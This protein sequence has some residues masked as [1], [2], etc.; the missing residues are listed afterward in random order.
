[1]DV[2]QLYNTIIANPYLKSLS[3]LVIFFILAKI[4]YIIFEKVF[5][6]AGES[7]QVD[8]TIKAED[9]AFFD[10]GKHDWHLEPGDFKL[11]IGRS[12]R[13]IISEKRF[14]VG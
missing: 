11:L 13:E 2:V 8:L 10:V 1:M 14:T 4:V 6:K 12:S 7:K 9:L 3:I 5:L